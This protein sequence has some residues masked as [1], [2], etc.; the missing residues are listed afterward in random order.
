MEDMVSWKEAFSIFSLTLTSYFPHRW[1]DWK[2]LY[3]FLI[4]RTYGQFTGGVWL[5]TIKP[6][7]S[8]LLQPTWLTGPQLTC[9]YTIFTQLGPRLVGTMI[10]HLN[11]RN[12][13]ALAHSRLSAD[14][15]T[16]NTAQLLT[17]P[18]NLLVVRVVRVCIA[19]QFALAM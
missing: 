2:C 11:L 3:Q 5:D 17:P 6:S 4:L 13:L 7:G 14:P 9:S 15:G 10:F 8:M 1:K 12:P 16:G 19:S 18:A